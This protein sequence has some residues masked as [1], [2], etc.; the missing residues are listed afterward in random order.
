MVWDIFYSIKSACECPFDK[1][2]A[3]GGQKLFG[4]F[5]KVEIVFQ[6]GVFL[7]ASDDVSVTDITEENIDHEEE[8]SAEPASHQAPPPPP[9]ICDSSWITDSASIA[10]S[11]DITDNNQITDTP[12]ITDST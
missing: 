5:L 12:F 1:G 9:T 4:Q 11:L 2:R 10:D 3:G 6:K 7:S 8:E